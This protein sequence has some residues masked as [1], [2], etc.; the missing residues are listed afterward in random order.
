[1]RNLLRMPR[2][3]I[4]TSLLVCLSLLASAASAAEL[5]GKV[6]KITDGDTVVILDAKKAQH[7]IRLNGID[8]PES[9]QPF[10][11]KSRQHLGGLIHEKEVRIVW[12]KR[13]RYG[14]ILGTVYLDQQNVNLEMVRSGFA[15]RFVRY[16]KDEEL[17]TAE[18]VARL[19]KIGLWAD[20]NPIAP[21]EWRKQ[22]ST[23]R[24]VLK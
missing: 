17:A 12:T 20:E 22:Q 7:K 13:D 8:A 5:R 21:W 19:A 18:N 14:R 4:H 10:G 23:L 16:S 3:T 9:Q 6:I 24:K 11:T 1:M 15:W 2:T